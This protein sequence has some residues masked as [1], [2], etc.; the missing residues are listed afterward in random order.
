M[1]DILLCWPRDIRLAN[2]R[3][4]SL[5]LGKYVEMKVRWSDIEIASRPR[6]QNMTANRKVCR[7]LGPFLRMYRDWCGR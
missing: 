3:T 7:V 4:G 5:A 6:W 1:D 2:D